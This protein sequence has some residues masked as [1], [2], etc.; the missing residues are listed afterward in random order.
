MT[1]KDERSALALLRLALT[2]L[3]RKDFSTK[4]PPRSPA[5]TE[6]V[7]NLAP[8]ET[9]QKKIVAIWCNYFSCQP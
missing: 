7:D 2:S 9:R 6:E 8:I 3:V 4:E 1:R 5:D